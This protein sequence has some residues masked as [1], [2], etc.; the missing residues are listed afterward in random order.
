VLLCGAALP[1]PGMRSEWSQA[2]E[3]ESLQGCSFGKGHW[4][5]L[6]GG[7]HWDICDGHREACMWVFPSLKEL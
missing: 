1:V 2:G 6:T 4:G 7:R 5:R 3:R